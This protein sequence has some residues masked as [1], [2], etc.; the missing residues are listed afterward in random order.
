V[1]D[2]GD[3]KNKPE[4]ARRVMDSL[5]SIMC[6]EEATEPKLKIVEVHDGVFVRIAAVSANPPLSSEGE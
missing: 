5:M 2:E 3:L 1:F 4:D 6:G